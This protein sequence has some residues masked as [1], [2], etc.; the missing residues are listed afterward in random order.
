MGQHFADLNSLFSAATALADSAA[1]LAMFRTHREMLGESVLFGIALQG[2]DLARQ[3]EAI[4]TYEI[5]AEAAEAAELPRPRLKLV[6][7]L[8]ALVRRTATRP[9]AMTAAERAHAAA[10]ALVEAGHLDALGAAVNSASLFA[11][12]ARQEGDAP[13]GRAILAETRRLARSARSA[14]AELWVLRNLLSLAL[15]AG[16]GVPQ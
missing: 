9:E 2:N 11:E 12:M 7:Q 4:R 16:S 3:G 6:L 15:S 8:A 5:G 13:R 10:A 14:N 1:R